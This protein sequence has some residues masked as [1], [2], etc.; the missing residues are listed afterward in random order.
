MPSTR[1]RTRAVETSA[2][3]SAGEKYVDEGDAAARIV[4]FL[5]Q[6]KVL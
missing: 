3:K 2:T 6:I 5:E 1:V 4:A